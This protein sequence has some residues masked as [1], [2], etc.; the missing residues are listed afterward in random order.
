L[1]IR[2][3]TDGDHAAW[4]PLWHQYLGYHGIWADDAP[5]DTWPR[6]MNP[7]EP[8]H[9][10]G[11]FTGDRL[12][13]IAHFIFHRHTWTAKNSCFLA[14]V[15]TAPSARRRGVARALVESVYERAAAAGA[16]NVYGTTLLGNEAS[17]KLYD[18]SAQRLN[19]V[20][21]RHQL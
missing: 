17:H 1:T 19:L 18:H 15:A 16:D 4:L 3:L 9:A 12:D 13:G 8:M 5:A 7:N 11:A 21:Y 14:D 10:I 2:T 20:V 6:L